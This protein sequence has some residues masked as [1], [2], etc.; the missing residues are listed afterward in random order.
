MQPDQLV[1]KV[2]NELFPSAI[3]KLKNVNSSAAA[4]AW[5]KEL[6]TELNKCI[7]DGE[8][9]QEEVKE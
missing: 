6:I 4:I 1:Q 5:R 9:P 2:T 3:D 8:Q 7:M